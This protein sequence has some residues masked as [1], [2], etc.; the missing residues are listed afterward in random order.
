VN[1]ETAAVEGLLKDPRCTSRE[2]MVA[3]VDADGNPVVEGVN[4]I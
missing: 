1:S 2:L 3:G 4:E